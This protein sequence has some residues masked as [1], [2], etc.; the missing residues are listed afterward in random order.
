M[1]R[2]MKQKTGKLQR[3]LLTPKAGALRRSIKLISLLPED[4]RKKDRIP[5]TNIRSERG[6]TVAD[7][8]NFFF[9]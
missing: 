4:Q 6:N 1:P 8:T 2:S 5:V 7:A 9:K 3:K